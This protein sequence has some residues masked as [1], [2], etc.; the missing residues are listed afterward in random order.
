M[1][2]TSGRN[3]DSG[4]SVGIS[5]TSALIIGIILLTIIVGALCAWQITH[6]GT[7][8]IKRRE[9]EYLSDLAGNTA[10]RMSLIMDE[11]YTDIRTIRDLFEREL[12]DAPAHKKREIMERILVSNRHFSWLGVVD[13]N[14]R[15]EIGTKGLLEGKSV[16]GR[17]WFE[18]AIKNPVFFGNLHPA[19]LLEPHIKN[20]DG[21]PLH[22]LDI[23]L[24]LHDSEGKVIG[25]LGS[26]MNWKMIEELVQ[27]TLN[28]SSSTI[29]LAAAVISN[30]NTIIYDTQG[31]SGN[32]S[33]LLPPES[34]DEMIEG[35][36]PSEQEKSFLVVSAVTPGKIFTGLNWQVVLRES[37]ATINSSIS[38]MRWQVVGLC[39][40]VGLIFSVFGLFTVRLITHPLKS[41]VDAITHFGDMEVVPEIKVD[42]HIQEVHN[43]HDSFL[44]MATNVVFQKERLL[45]TQIEIVK[46]LARAGEF[47]DNETGNHVFRMSQCSARLAELAGLDSNQVDMIRLASTMHDIGKIGIPDH[48][49]LKPGRF[50]EAERAIMERHPE[51]GARILTGLH[52]PLTVL[53]RSISLCHHEKWDG[54][55]YPAGL[56]G[57]NIP[58]EGRIIAICDVFDALLSSRPYKQA[59]PIEKVT[60]LIR[61]QAGQHFDPTLAALFLAHLDEFIEIRSN[62][63]DDPLPDEEDI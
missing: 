27:Q 42:H 44:K 48:V 43:L 17:N 58:L 53:A 63:L 8:D 21:V 19:K 14:G 25:V 13:I 2:E 49:L 46:A 16:A 33:E 3:Q 59:W 6:W 35:F 50:N 38:D 36:W 28:S 7:L 15:I 4:S 37:A 61:E 55:G 52:T 5:I 62:Y 51:I 54:T 10:E 29:P 30:D 11:R 31:V 41:L 56:S 22:L 39:V 47:R 1:Q 9:S 60:A 20:P 45:E 34:R 40:L 26:H 57:E 32:V 23:S 18:E 24:P 12:K